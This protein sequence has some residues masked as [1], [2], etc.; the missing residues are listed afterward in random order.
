[1]PGVGSASVAN[2]APLEN[3]TGGYPL[4]Y[5]RDG[6]LMRVE[7]L[8][9]DIDPGYLRTLGIPLLAGRDFEPEDAARKPVPLILNQNAAR[10]LFGG[11]NPL[12]KVVMCTDRRIGA[13]QVVGIAGDARMLGVAIAPGPQAFAPLMGGWG[14]AAVVVARAEVKA[15][16]LAPAIRTAVRE[17]DPGSPAPQID[18]LDDV[19]GE[20][21]AEP[22]FYMTLLDSFALLGLALAATGVY[23]VIA[24]VVAQRT[25]EFGIRLA[26]GATP[27]EIVGMVLG[28]GAR[29]IAAGAIAG[30]AGALAA[31]R[32][33]TSLLYEVKPNDPGTLAATVVLLLGIALAAC[34]LAA[35]RA[36][37]V[38]VSAALR[39]E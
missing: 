22:R 36:S 6:S 1:M 32:M 28:S 10:T 11:E 27:R 19:F 13:M 35:R 24:Y 39:A 14:Y 15:A 2:A 38:E 9:R 3:I 31:T 37:R 25:H 4:E 26:L 12:G 34:W 29:V 5:R 21:V 33:L 30:V 18:A 8:G 7:P 17:L 16:A 20:Q 23:G